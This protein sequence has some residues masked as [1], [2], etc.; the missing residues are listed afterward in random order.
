MASVFPKWQKP[1]PQ[2]WGTIVIGASI[3]IKAVREDI[4]TSS[5]A[6]GSFWHATE[7]TGFTHQH[8]GQLRCRLTRGTVKKGNQQGRTVKTS[9]GHPCSSCWLAHG[10]WGLLAID[11]TWGGRGP[12]FMLLSLRRLEGVSECQR[13]LTIAHFWCQ[14]PPLHNCPLLVLTYIHKGIKLF[15]YKSRSILIFVSFLLY[16]STKIVRKQ[17]LNNVSTI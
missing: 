12:G 7:G 13:R 16:L 3:W 10:F 4:C 6:P 15:N 14:L 2:A 8:R 9:D 5:V 11:G 1:K 17:N